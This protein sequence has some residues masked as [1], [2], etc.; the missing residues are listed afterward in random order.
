[1]RKLGRIGGTSF[2]SRLRGVSVKQLYDQPTSSDS[3]IQQV[4]ARENWADMANFN[5]QLHGDPVSLMEECTE[6]SMHG[7]D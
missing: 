7:D 6:G 3:D 1:M 4:A 2:V 5:M